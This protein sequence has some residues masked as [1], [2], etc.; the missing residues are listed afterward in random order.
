MTI[1]Y[2]VISFRLKEEFIHCKHRRCSANVV[3]PILEV[4]FLFQKKCFSVRHIY[5]DM[6]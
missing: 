6:F 2:V 5:G 4:L 1:V 3:H